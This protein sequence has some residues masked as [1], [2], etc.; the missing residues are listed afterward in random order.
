MTDERQPWELAEEESGEPVED[1]PPTSEPIDERERGR[2][3]DDEDRDDDR[4]DRGDYAEQDAD[5]HAD[6]KGPA[7]GAGGP[8]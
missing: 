2:G 6:P 8:A 3:H 4:P 7:G 5:E 1:V